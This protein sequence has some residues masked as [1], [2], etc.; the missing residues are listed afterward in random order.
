MEPT[1]WEREEVEK[2]DKLL[3]RCQLRQIAFEEQHRRIKE[4]PS[5]ELVSERLR[6][7]ATDLYSVLDYLCYLVYCH[8]RNGGRFSL[9]PEARNVKFPFK[10]NLRRSDVP[11][12]ETWSS[13][14]FRILIGVPIGPYDQTTNDLLPWW[15]ELILN[16]QIMTEVDADGHV[17]PQPE[18]TEDAKTFRALHYLRNCTVHRG[19]V[20]ATVKNGVLYYNKQAGSHEVVH[21]RIDER[22]NDPD[23]QSLEVTPTY[24]IEIPPEGNDVSRFQSITTVASRLLAFVRNIRKSILDAVFPY[25]FLNLDDRDRN[26]RVRFGLVD[27][28]YIGDRHYPDFREEIVKEFDLW[29]V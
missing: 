14:Q 1:A 22:E 29:A 6:Y 5:Q 28:L 26:D 20:T 10:L 2:I 19:L 4:I 3:R 16:C 9:S 7:F 24:W 21:G 12:Q 13:K 15:Q 11:G 23:W 18:Q 17:I 8:F 25:H 27:G